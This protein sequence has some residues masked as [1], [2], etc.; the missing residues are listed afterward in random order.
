[1][2]FLLFIMPIFEETIV[3]QII[4]SNGEEVYQYHKVEKA[5]FALQEDFGFH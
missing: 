2:Y 3:V 5:E 4:R 1:M